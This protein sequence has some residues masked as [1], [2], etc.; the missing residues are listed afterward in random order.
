MSKIRISILALLL[1]APPAIAQ[2][3]IDTVVGNF[4]PNGSPATTVPVGRSWAAVADDSGNVYIAGWEVQMVFRVDTE[5]LVSVVAGTG[6]RGYSGDGGPATSA[7]LNFPFSVAVDG[8]G[9]VFIADTYNHVVR[10]VNPAGIITT[11]AGSWYGY[12]GD[13]GPATSA[14]LAN[15]VGLAVDGAGN[16]FIADLSNHRVR[17]VDTAGIITTAAGTGLPGYSGD[18]GPATS[19]RM[20]G[21]WGVAVGDDENLFIADHDLHRVRK[22]DSAGIISTVAGN[23]SY[24]YGGDGGPAISASLRNPV[25]VAVDGAGN[26]F[27]ADLRNQRI[28]KVDSAGIITTMAGSG[29]YGHDGDGGPATSARL[30][31]PSGVAVDGAGNVLIADRGNSYI[32]KVDT[33]GIIH[34]IAGNG[35]AH[36]FGEGIPAIRA[37]FQYPTS[38][39]A[40]G[41][42]NLFIADRENRRV[43]KVDAAGV[44]STVAGTGVNGYR[45]DGGPATD[46]WLSDNWSVAVDGAGN[47]F[48]GDGSRVRKV[49]VTGT[50]TTVAG[51]NVW[52]YGGDGGPATDARLYR[53][54]GLAVDGA[55][56]LYIADS[57]NSRIRKVDAAGIITTVAGNGTPAY[58]G[59]GGPATL[60][61]LRRP[62]D[63]ALDAT[64]NL[65]IAD[66]DDHRVR[67][68]DTGGTI[69]TVAGIGIRG[70]SGDGGPATSAMLNFPAA[71]AFDGL[72]N[73]FIGDQGGARVRRVDTAGIIDVVAGSGIRGYSGDGGPATSATMT[74]P[75]G[76]AADGTG[77]LFIVDTYNHR[78][79]KVGFNQPPICDAGGPYVAQCAGATTWLGP[80]GTGSSDPEG[81]AISF[82][83]TTDCPGGAF[84]DDASA[85]PVLTVDSLAPGVCGP[86]S[87]VAT[88]MVTDDGGLSNT[89]DSAVSIDDSLAPALAVDITPITVTDGD[90]SGDEPAAL[91]TASASD[92]CD[93]QVPVDDDAPAAF[94]AGQA[95]RVTY[96]AT[97]DCSNT[98][99]AGI[100]V[101][102]LFGADIAVS[103]SR[104]N[105]GPGTFPQAAREPLEDLEVC[106]YDLAEGSCAADVCGGASPQDYSCILDNCDPVNAG[107]NAACCTTDAAGECTINVPPGEYV[108]L[109][110]DPSGTVP[111][112][113]LGVRA[114]ALVCGALKPVR[115]QQIVRHDGRAMPAQT[116]VRTGSELLIIEPAF[117][118]WDETEEAY[119]VVFE[120]VGDW[121]AESSVTPPE[122]FVSDHE[123]L[124]E[125][126]TDEVEA[127]QFLL[128]D[129]GSDWVPTE[130]R[131]VLRHQGRREVVLSR[132]GVR[133]SEGLAAAKGLDRDGRPLG[134]DGK[135]K[136][137]PGFDPRGEWPVEIAGWI[138]PSAV[139]AGWT[140]K[141]E[142]RS[143]VDLE[144]AV[145]RGQGQVVKRL[146]AG[147]LLPG[148]HAFSWDGAELG[149]GEHFLRLTAGELVQKVRL[150]EE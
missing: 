70:N 69:T 17:K 97:D 94:P 24:G 109:S 110:D 37:L 57:E 53:V 146:A 64:G 3:I 66:R 90:C 105:V 16:L 121:S 133:L 102:V 31:F 96:S 142:V 107:F 140:V 50:I 95:T 38:I 139:D 137:H 77:S 7:T 104:L 32:R 129:V 75:W 98:A 2:P 25:D 81:E 19:A 79:R 52:G 143:A 4:D 89:C 120:S 131:H 126:V 6:F 33:A 49:D 35:F 61:S 138:E 62:Y 42:G 46:A 83:W 125:Q 20:E 9:N 21:P 111:P 65:F 45:G 54:R 86:L 8:A 74:S 12:G 47:L 150:R 76:I 130:T 11:F 124:A 43:R 29:S 99:T 78:V 48:I 93:P 80:D 88:L 148:E 5:G 106:A 101:T 23:G 18:G 149:P 68:V 28:R 136:P 116:T 100:D 91:P 114:G 84:D 92:G 27:I 113:P 144:L 67:R 112:K 71:L 147:S 115:L 132:I 55:G 22:V 82:A 44:V 36:F 145:T 108:L 13:G 103:A 56:Q 87:C 127:V 63:V 135:P 59:D 128:T 141:L 34:S 118:E 122:G 40:D 14:R 39:A 41:A 30:A 134:P 15:P 117:V 51:T 1:A 119:P 73:L 58:G 10:K 26:L 60:A 72:G 123:M 85:A